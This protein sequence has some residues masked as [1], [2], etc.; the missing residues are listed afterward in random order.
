MYLTRVLIRFVNLFFIANLMCNV[1]I[2]RGR[3]C[4]CSC[5]FGLFVNMSSECVTVYVCVCESSENEWRHRAKEMPIR[6]CH[7]G[8]EGGGAERSKAWGAG[9]GRSG[10]G[11]ARRSF[12]CWW[13]QAPDRTPG[14]LTQLL[15]CPN[16]TFSSYRLAPALLCTR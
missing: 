4:S 11:N 3:F 14:L 7:V 6:P 10:V 2:A 8:R 1:L 15:T 16:G 9:V 13:R 12:V 5:W